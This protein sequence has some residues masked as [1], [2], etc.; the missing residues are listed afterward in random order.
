MIAGDGGVF[1][2]RSY[3]PPASQNHLGG[4]RLHFCALTNI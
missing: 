4:T 3:E 2:P 1:R